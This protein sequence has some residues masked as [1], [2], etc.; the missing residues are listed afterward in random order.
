M[1]VSFARRCS[2]IGIHFCLYN[3]TVNVKDRV[4]PIPCRRPIPDTIGHRYT[5]TDSDTGLLT[6]EMGKRTTGLLISAPIL[7]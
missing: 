3:I 7:K 1:N 6:V 2:D 5:D 4:R